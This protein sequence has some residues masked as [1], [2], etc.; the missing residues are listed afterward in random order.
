MK[1]VINIRRTTFI[2]LTIFIFAWLLVCNAKSAHSESQAKSFSNNSIMSKLN[3][4]TGLPYPGTY[5]LEKIFSVPS[6]N[7]LDTNS[8]LQP[9]SKY[10]K[11][12]ITLLTFFYQRCSDANGCPYAMGIFHSVKNKLEQ[13]KENKNLV[14]FVNISFDPERD[15]PMMMRGLEK[16]T[17]SKNENNIEW[18][19]LTTS[20]VN[21]LMPL[22]NG[23]GQNVDIVINQLTGSQSLTYQHVLKVYLIDQ[24]GYV[25]EIYSTAYLSK[26][27]ILNDI[28]TLMLTK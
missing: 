10:T 26:N 12:K 24:E 7:V 28:E 22:I 25:R 4:S 3:K 21:D 6:H 19:F 2:G 1:N 5:K 13:N 16:Q 8:K 15:T 20:S 23:F 9:I 14:R 11:G 17:K 27:M 18:D